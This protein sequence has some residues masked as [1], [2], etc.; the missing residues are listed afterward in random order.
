MSKQVVFTEAQAKR[1]WAATKQ[2][3]QMASKATGYD[4]F[5]RQSPPELPV[6]IR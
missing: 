1:I 2:M 3:E 5:A 6:Y 4:R